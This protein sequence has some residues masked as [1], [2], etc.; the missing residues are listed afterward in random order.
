M[1]RTQIQL[2]P[3]TYK[4]M[5]RRANA[6]QCSVSEL[7]RRSI[8]EKLRRQDLA[9]KWQASLAVLGRHGSGLG[10]LSENHDKYL[11]DGW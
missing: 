5:K 7:A 3:A 2:E 4:E 1:I 11:S 8:E 10:D 9:D 6:L